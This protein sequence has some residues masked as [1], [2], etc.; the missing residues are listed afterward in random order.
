MTNADS[1]NGMDSGVRLVRGVAVPP[2]IYL[3]DIKDTQQKALL[4]TKRENE[5][6]EIASSQLVST[7][8]SASRMQRR[9]RGWLLQLSH[10]VRRTVL[11]AATDDQDT[12]G[13]QLM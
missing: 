12:P 8:C 4:V 5:T 3:S 11:I 1:Y 7:T 6:A 10:P 9:K 2:Y 13:T